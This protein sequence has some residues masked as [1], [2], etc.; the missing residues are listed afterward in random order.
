MIVCHISSVKRIKDYA[1]KQNT[2]YIQGGKGTTMAEYR[3]LLKH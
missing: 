1:S 3:E 2:L